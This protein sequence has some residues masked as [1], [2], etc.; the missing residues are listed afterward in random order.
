MKT[1]SFH[2]IFFLL[3]IFS[4]QPQQ[5]GTADKVFLN[6]KVYTV[7]ENQSWAEAVA[8]SGNKIIYVGDSE[9]AKTLIGDSTD[10]IDLGGKMMLPG[11]IESHFHTTLGAAFGQGLWLAHLDEKQEFI[12]A[13]QKYS[14]ENPDLEFIMGF[15]WKPYA[16]PQSGP[17]KEDLDDITTEKPIFLFDVTAHAAWVNSKALEVAEID[18]NTEDPQPGFSY[19]YRDAS[20]EATGW[21]IEV[22]TEFMVLNKIQPMSVDYV[23]QG[24]KTWMAKWSAAG[25]TTATDLGYVFM[26]DLETQKIGYE[27]L[28]NVEKDGGLRTRV[29]SSFYAQP[30]SDP[31]LDWKAMK[32]ACPDTRYV[33]HRILKIGVDGDASSKSIKLYEPYI[34]DPEDY[35]TSVYAQEE[36]NKIVTNAVGENIHLHFHAMGDASVGFILTSIEEARKMYPN[37]TSRFALA[38]VYLIH[39][40][41]FERCKAVDLVPTFSGNWLAP[42]PSDMDVANRL[43][44]DQRYNS[45][46]PMQS[47]VDLGVTCSFGSDFPASGAIATY[48]MLDQMQ[49]GITRQF[50]SG[51]G[52]IFPPEDER[53]S[54]ET[55]IKAATI[56]GAYSLG[57][58]DEIGSISEGKKADLIVLDQNLFDVEVYKIHETQ[59]LLTM[60]DGE[61]MHDAFFGLGNVTDGL[62]VLGLVS[63][64]SEDF[65][66]LVE[67]LIKNLPDNTDFHGNRCAT[68]L[69]DYIYK[70]LKENVKK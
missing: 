13:V 64:E 65:D 59:V 33:Q 1:K 31:V 52:D 50:L 69:G 60:V 28:R 41:D 67:E 10:L 32:E 58:E 54:L 63:Q 44:G 25:I 55:A 47:L 57:L 23:E 62:R 2:F 49:Y 46:Y 27:V 20:G 14:D 66:Q 34:D 35:G 7:N 61:I 22:A 39:P 4:C 38:H 53:I 51:K 42:D 26:G 56:N 19:F 45:W 30:G 29:Y 9:T 48:K 36:L 6:G 21:L 17:I 68:D 8:I 3:V 15:G 12:N 11:F 40:K 37:S 43:L 5:K 24:L 18:K 70:S 16:F